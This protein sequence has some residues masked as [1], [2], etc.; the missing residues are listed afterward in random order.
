MDLKTFWQLIADAR[1]DVPDPSDCCAVVAAAKTRLAALPPAEIVSAQQALWDVMALSYRNPLWAAAYVI[2]GGCSDD[3]FD[4][5]RGWLLTQGEDVYHAAATSPETLA[6]LP[7]VVTAAGSGDEFEC[8]GALSIAW[9]A[10]LTATGMRL[11][12]DA[13]TIRY[14]EL[15]PDWS[16][17]FDD[18]A[19]IARRLPRLAALYGY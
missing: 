8:E 15:D 19:E 13:F 6:D 4:Y 1:A 16:F 5:F 10:H 14:P 11:P 3:G 18:E 7:A 12:Q 9:D 17:D 2:N